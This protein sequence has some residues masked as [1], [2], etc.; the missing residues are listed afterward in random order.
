[1]R[2]LFFTLNFFVMIFTPQLHSVDK[3][4]YPIINMD[5]QEEPDPFAGLPTSSGNPPAPTPSP[6]SPYP[7]GDKGNPWAMMD[8]TT[9]GSGTPWHINVS[10]DD[11]KGGYFSA[12]LGDYTNTR[13]QLRAN[14]IWKQQAAFQQNY[15]K[16]QFDMQNAYNS[17]AAERDRLEAAGY[18]PWMYG[19]GSAG[20]S[21][22]MGS[23]VAGASSPSG[24]GFA[25]GITPPGS[26]MLN[27]AQAFKSTLD[28]VNALA[29]A[30]FKVASIKPT[31][32]NMAANSNYTNAR[33]FYQ[34]LVNNAWNQP[35]KPQSYKES[36]IDTSEGTNSDEASAN[37]NSAVSVT[38]TSSPDSNSDSRAQQG[39]EYAARKL[40]DDTAS[41]ASTSKTLDDLNEVRVEARYLGSGNLMN[42]F[43]K[44]QTHLMAADA[45][46]SRTTAQRNT[47]TFD[48]DVDYANLRNENV[49]SST[50]EN[51][52]RAGLDRAQTDFTNTQNDWLPKTSQSQINLNSALSNQANSNARLNNANSSRVEFVND[53]MHNNKQLINEYF[54]N[55]LK[56]NNN[57]IL[58][59]LDDDGHVVYRF[60][61]HA[62]NYVGALGD[63]LPNIDIASGNSLGNV[64][65][66]QSSQSSSTSQSSGGLTSSNRS[67]SSTRSTSSTSS[68]STHS[69]N[70]SHSYR[71]GFRHH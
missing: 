16:E 37:T 9:N 26:G 59:Q 50:A 64:E 31:L 19:N 60:L 35:D 39:V 20:G 30:G 33:T 10:N 68:S 54:T 48:A 58:I 57:N 1:M 56:H 17:P 44:D 23:S 52:A 27:K 51:N 12:W 62:G 13:S 4:S 42:K 29:D 65:S 25:G 49:S 41:G 24:S 21:S 69:G 67:N 34:T 6:S 55:E 3:N 36:K 7:T 5:G 2:L 43:V 18:S 40:M 38:P 28:G 14:D 45:L 66:S 70:H 53:W 61:K 15:W 71:F 32:Q 22:S 8:P 46:N 63:A 11:Y 47:E